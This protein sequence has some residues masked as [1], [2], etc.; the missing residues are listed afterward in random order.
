MDLLILVLIVA[1]IGFVIWLATE[2]IPMPA[3]W[4]EILQA[5]ALVLLVIFLIMKLLAG[6]LPNVL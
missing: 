1:L 6:H 3:G 5:V 2:K 4:K